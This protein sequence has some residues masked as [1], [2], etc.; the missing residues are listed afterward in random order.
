MSYGWDGRLEAVSTLLALMY[1]VGMYGIVTRV[2]MPRL[3]VLASQSHSTIPCCQRVAHC[4]HQVLQGLR[5]QSKTCTCCTCQIHISGIQLHS[6]FLHVHGQHTEKLEPNGC[7]HLGRHDIRRG[8]R[9]INGKLW[10][11][12]KGEL[13]HVGEC[14]DCSSVNGSVSEWTALTSNLPTRA[15]QYHS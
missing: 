11:R 10:A 14:S 4:L 12:H 7:I 9:G 13:T 1:P 2:H 3:A 6:S 15:S 5:R 8:Q